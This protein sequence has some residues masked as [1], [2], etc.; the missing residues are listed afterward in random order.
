MST[1]YE[2]A[3]YIDGRYIA[4]LSK[5][6]TAIYGED[7]ALTL[8]DAWVT[9]ES[10][11]DD[12][13]MLK[14]T[15]KVSAP[16]VETGDINVN[17]YLTLAIVDY[18]QYRLLLDKYKE[19]TNQKDFLAAQIFYGKFLAKISQNEDNKIGSP[20]IVIPVGVGVLK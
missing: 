8:R 6:S 2:Y 7:V 15:S 16:T 13:I 1:I 9:P 19:T 20:R 14:Y 3:Y 10:D 5:G 12:G 4:I 11:D 17:E 18:V